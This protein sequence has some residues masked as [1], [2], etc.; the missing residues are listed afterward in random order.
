M[1]NLKL[2][3][4]NEFR[5][6]DVIVEQENPQ[7]PKFMK[8]TGP[9]I[10]AEEKNANGRIYKQNIMES[11]VEDYIDEYIKSGRAMGELNHPTHTEIDQK[12]VCHRVVDLKQDGNVWTGTSIVLCSSEDGKI[13]GTPNGD[14]LASI[15]Q[16]GGKPG[17]S[18][19]G[20][21]NI[22][23]SGIVDEYK[24]ITID[25]VSNPSGP[26]CYVDGILEAKSFMIDNHGDI[27]ETAYNKLETKLEKMPNSNIVT[28]KE[29]YM[30]NIIK[31]FIKSI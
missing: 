16:H 27:V 7:S 24:L 3:I 30:V 21:G 31:E 19:R 6:Y 12:E 25:A 18:T 1:N 10:V 23:E 20:V 2:I 8:I 11:A 28:I 4:E 26:G 22:T 14:I 29:D 15:L 17:M 9:Y 13:K 5:D